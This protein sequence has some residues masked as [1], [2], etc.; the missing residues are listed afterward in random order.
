MRLSLLVMG[1]LSFLFGCGPRRG[2]FEQKDGQWLF[3]GLPLSG[4]D[5]ASFA[6]L[7]DYFGRDAHGAYYCTTERD[8]RE[9]F[10]VRR[11]RALPLPGA[12]PASFRVLGQRYAR[13]ARRIYFESEPFEVRD[14]ESFQILEYHFARDRQV[15]YFAQRI[16]AGSDGPSFT[17][18][19]SRYAKDKSGVYHG[20]ILP[21]EGGRPRIVVTR[22]PGADPASFQ[23][24]E[25]GYA[26]DAQQAYYGARPLSREAGFEVLRSDYAKDARRVYH[27]GAEVAGADAATFAVLSP[28]ADDADARD[29]RSRY[30]QGKKLP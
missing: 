25:S 1:L 28:P 6:P 18:L 12:E 21:G 2:P 20:D 14:L 13:D 11:A 8:S 30:L 7:D 27:R 29:A 3:K 10:L 19:D 26:R 17:G 5:S 4:V 24:L 16:V 22:L 9:L 15:G 23:P